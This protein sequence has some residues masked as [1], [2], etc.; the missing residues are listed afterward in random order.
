MTEQRKYILLA[1]S[2]MTP[3]IVT[4]TLYGIHKK[5]P[6]KMPS[7]IIV[8]TTSS[9]CERLNN[10]L[11]GKD[12]YLDQFC[13]DY[14]YAS[15]SLDIRVPKLEGIELYDVRTDAEQEATADFITDQVRKLTQDDR[16]AI[17]ASLAGG[18]KTM[19]F[20]LGYAMSLF[21]R[22]QDSLSHVLVNEPYEQVPDFY[23]PTPIPVFR[24]D[25]DK[26]NR[27]DLSKAEVTLGEIPLVLMREDLPN[28]LIAK[29]NISYTQVVQQANQAKKLDLESV[30][31]TLDRKSMT[32]LCNDLPVKLS[33]EQFAFYTWMARDS[34]DNPKEGIEPVNSEMM[35][36]ELTQRLKNWIISNLPS[37]PAVDYDNKNLAELNEESDISIFKT[38]ATTLKMFGCKDEY[39]ILPDGTK[40][41]IYVLDQD[42]NKM[43]SSQKHIWDR[44]LKQTNNKFQLA[45]GKKLAEYYI[46]KT[47]SN[48]KKND[49]DKRPIQCKG[50]VI[51]PRNI[52]FVG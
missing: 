22:P 38:G 26:K 39:E 9:G 12:N 3:Q 40:N 6:D 29:E 24:A 27:H 20:I 47:V 30:S 17:H 31:I 4:E 49:S 51:E 21:G 45:L 28:D 50:L 41:I 43:W 34:K 11:L 46:I 23:Y 2:G 37:N 7:E 8:L 52:H 35:V 42:Q 19:G 14:G 15:I 10:A 1:V 44:L 48:I 33:D 18:R 32:V 16:I 36:N 5:S 13:T 25:R